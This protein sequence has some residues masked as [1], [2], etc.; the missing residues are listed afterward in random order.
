[1]N[2]K[3]K[4]LFVSASLGLGGS[5]RC[6][7]EMIRR[8]DLDRYDIT[9]LALNRVENMQKFDP[10]IRII[11]GIPEFE[12]LGMPMSKFVPLALKTGEF[13]KLVWKSICWLRIKI[14]KKHIS[15]YFWQS[16]SRY[17]PKTEEEFDAVVGYGQ[18][19][20][21]YYAIDKVPNVKKRVLW[22]NTDLEKAKYHPAYI[23]RFYMTAD[24]VAAD[25]EHGKKALQ[26]LYP[27]IG[28]RVY[29]YPNM[30]D[31]DG[32]VKKSGEYAAAYPQNEAG[33]HILTVGRMVEAKAFHLAVGAAEILKRRRIPFKWYL[34]GDGPLRGQIAEQIRRVGVEDCV[35]LLGAR[36][37][38]Y[39]WFAG[40]DIY[41][42][43]S[44][45]EGSCMTI[46]EAMVFN[47]PVVS[48][49][50]PAVYEKIEDGKN[51]FICEMNAQSIADKVECLLVDKA[52][53]QKMSDDT[54]HNKGRRESDIQQFYNM[55]EER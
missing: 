22:L 55:L 48:T 17:I 36:R 44:I 13:H 25:S 16:L 4:I 19:L 39:P 30:L 1:M 52:L 32:I 47:K 27:E 24:I 53:R 33:C 5:E 21:T 15:Q 35:I 49:D 45:Y 28:E 40:C 42:Q 37:N 18:G 38:P 12:Y 14:G 51:G 43:T 23:R 41:V 46:N 2:R 50:F 7:A 34:I 54:R 3:K 9:V 29:R 6:M 20:A 10:R 11:E 31:V 8:I 26:R